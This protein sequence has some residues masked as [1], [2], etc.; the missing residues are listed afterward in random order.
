MVSGKKGKMVFTSRKIRS[1]DCV[2]DF[3]FLLVD[4]MTQHPSHICISYTGDLKTYLTKS[5][6]YV[7]EI[8]GACY[9]NSFSFFDKMKWLEEWFVYMTN[10]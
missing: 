6:S 7:R 9:R 3:F 1:G 10:R 2:F 5:K 8:R 4:V